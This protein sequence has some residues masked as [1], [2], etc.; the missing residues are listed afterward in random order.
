MVS[1]GKPVSPEIKPQDIECYLI[2]DGTDYRIVGYGK[3]LLM[4]SVSGEVE[5]AVEMFR[6]M[7]DPIVGFQDPQ[8][9]F[10]RS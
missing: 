1:S 3:R 8:A 10:A 5:V 6:Q 7:P 9:I 2:A 4:S